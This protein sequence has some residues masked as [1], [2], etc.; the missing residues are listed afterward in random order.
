ME[1]IFASN[2]QHKLNEIQAIAGNKISLKSLKDISCF[3]EIPETGRTFEINAGQKSRYIYDRFHVSCFADD[4]GLEIDGLNGEPGVDSAH[5]SGSRDF[6]KNMEL[7][8][9][10]LGDNPNR[11]ARFRTV[12]SLLLNGEE[13]LFEGTIEGN[14]TREICGTKGF[15]Y[16]PIFIPEGYDVTFAEMDAEEKNRISHRAVAVRKMV[17]AALSSQ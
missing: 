7:V 6:G 15:G 3:D 1:L 8:L 16:D 10:N 12:I 9:S 14:I 11:R 17:V 13:H 4:S 2:N 5:Y